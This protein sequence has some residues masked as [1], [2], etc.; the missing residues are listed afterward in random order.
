MIARFTGLRR[1][2]NCHAAPNW[3]SARYD[4]KFADDSVYDV[5]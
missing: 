1:L 3:N 5:L 2:M 4:S